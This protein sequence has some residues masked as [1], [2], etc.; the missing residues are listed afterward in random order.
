M[1]RASGSR[2][3]H[4]VSISA[5]AAH[6][7]KSTCQRRGLTV[8]EVCFSAILEMSK[9]QPAFQN[10]DGGLNLVGLASPRGMQMWSLSLP[11]CLWDWA[12]IPFCLASWQ[13]SWRVSQYE[14]RDCRVDRGAQTCFHCGLVF[15]PLGHLSNHT[16]SP[17]HTVV[18]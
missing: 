16:S 7:G 14:V 2:P 8:G 10:L 9:V 12:Q 15:Q 6:A 11:P 13:Y 1:E 3:K 4:Q 18:F 17:L 5:C